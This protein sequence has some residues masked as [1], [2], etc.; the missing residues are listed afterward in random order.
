MGQFFLPLP[1]S[2]GVFFLQADVPEKFVPVLLRRFFH[3]PSFFTPVDQVRFDKF[4]SV[5]YVDFVP[6]LSLQIG[7]FL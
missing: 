2:G 6:L 4:G 5:N 1:P 7:K 3:S